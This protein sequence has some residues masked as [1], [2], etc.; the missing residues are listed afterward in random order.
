MCHLAK[1]IERC[2]AN[3]R[4]GK[5]K[6]L[7]IKI[8]ADVKLAIDRFH[9]RNHVDP[10]CRLRFNPNN[11]PELKDQDSEVCEQVHPNLY[12]SLALLVYSGV[13]NAVFSSII[14]RLVSLVNAQVFRWFGRLKLVLRHC[15]AVFFE[16]MVYHLVHIHNQRKLMEWRRVSSLDVRLPS[17]HFLQGGKRGSSSKIRGK[18]MLLY[19]R[20]REWVE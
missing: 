12:V 19:K 14:L 7:S 16:Y 8:L 9:F 10:L 20:A 11:I 5:L 13:L 15:G 3:A 4:D 6:D 2:A 1:I 18:K 17:R